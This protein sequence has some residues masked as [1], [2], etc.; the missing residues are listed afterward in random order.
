MI[1]CYKCPECGERGEVSRSINDD[2]DFPACP[3]CNTLMERDWQ[4]ENTSVSG[5]YH[6]P[7]V[8]RSMAIHPDEV[9][10]HRKR[11]PHIQLKNV[12]GFFAP[13]LTNLRERRAYTRARGWVDK[14]AFV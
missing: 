3:L 9:A 12:D 8:S 11:F 7:I 1:Y 4:A 5:D 13:V 10:E 2:E 6:D 14:N